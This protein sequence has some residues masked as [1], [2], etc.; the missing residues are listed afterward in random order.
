MASLLCDVHTLTEDEPTE[1]ER[2]AG[3]RADGRGMWRDCFMGTEFR[4]CKMKRVLEV[5]G[6]DGCTTSCMY[7]MPANC[8]LK[9]G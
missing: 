5:D 1:T 3:C 2:A 9:N 6:G 4:L 7:L 8:A